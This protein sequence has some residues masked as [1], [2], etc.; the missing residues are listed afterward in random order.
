MNDELDKWRKQI[1][2]LDEKV[3]NLLVKRSKIVKKIG[4]FKKR[5]NIS[6]LD[7]N[8]WNKVLTSMLSKGNEL[9]L[10]K[11]FVKKLYDLIHEYSIK[12][13]KEST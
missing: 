8:R 3:L 12:I 10:S 13:Q 4:Q 11:D 7:K 9:G 1:D 6:P 5:Q 2:E